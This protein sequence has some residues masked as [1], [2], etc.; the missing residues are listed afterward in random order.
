MNYNIL[1]DHALLISGISLLLPVIYVSYTIIANYFATLYIDDNVIE[2]ISLFQKHN[3]I[4]GVTAGSSGRAS[5]VKYTLI[6]KS[7]EFCKTRFYIP[8][9]IMK[10]HIRNFQRGKISLHEIMLYCYKHGTLDGRY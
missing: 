5:S 8:S 7:S 2:I 4:L 3:A 9:R 1:S 10:R 6:P